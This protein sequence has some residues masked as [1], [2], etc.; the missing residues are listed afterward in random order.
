MERRRNFFVFESSKFF[1]DDVEAAVQLNIDNAAKFQEELASIERKHQKAAERRKAVIVR[2]IVGQHPAPASPS[3]TGASGAGAS[4]NA[5]GGAGSGAETGQVP[6]GAEYGSGWF[7]RKMPTQAELKN[8]KTTKTG[9][10]KQ[11]EGRLMK[12]WRKKWFI[13]NGTSLYYF[14]TD[15]DLRAKGFIEIGSDCLVQKA[16]EYT[17]GQEFSFGLFHPGGRIFFFSAESEGEREAWIA[18]LSEVV[19]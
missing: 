9:W 14:E 5:Q 13:L 15:K 10:L 2:S 16:D 8:A 6:G 18:T 12:S 1:Q 17:N 11:Q 7:S 19:M 4:G 3:G